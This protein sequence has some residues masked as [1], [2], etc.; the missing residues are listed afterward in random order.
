MTVENETPDSVDTAATENTGT[1]GLE[2]QEQ[3]EEQAAQQEGEEGKEGKQPNEPEK[4]KK[5][6]AQERI[7]QLARENAEL[8]RQQA[9]QQAQTKQS[10]LKR[11][12]I[13]DFEDFSK[14]EE[15]LEDY[16]AAKAE[17]RVLARLNER[18]SQKA[19]SS[20]EVEIQTAIV[21]LEEEGIDFNSYVQKANE[22]PE[23]PIQLDQF[24]LSTVETLRLAK[25]LLDDE[26]TYLAISQMNPVQAAVKIGQIIE[27]RKTKTAPPVTK[28]PKPIKPVNGNASAA[29]STES[30]SDN[31]FLKSRGL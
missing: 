15:A 22:L 18:E 24:G 5:S 8:R 17:E 11:P 20:Q 30:M 3:Q 13:D 12:V 7:E 26:D 31:E 19:A 9:Q 16:H 2:N 14:Y 27:G 23:L 6:R 21:E 4:P 1:E 29:R 28:A 25:D 10:D